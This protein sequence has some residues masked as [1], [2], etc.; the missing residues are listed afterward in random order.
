MRDD[1]SRELL[2]VLAHKYQA[3][4]RAL[5]LLSGSSGD[6]PVVMSFAV[7]VVCTVSQSVVDGKSAEILQF[8]T[9]SGQ[10][11]AERVVE[12]ADVD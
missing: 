6:F 1:E 3:Q 5:G 2:E 9:N 8:Y 4:E 12:V 11:L 7:S 10:F